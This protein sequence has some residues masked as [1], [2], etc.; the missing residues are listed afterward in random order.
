MKDDEWAQ[1]IIKDWDVKGMLSK[2]SII[3]R[4][5]KEIQNSYAIREEEEA[6]LKGTFESICSEEGLLT[7]TTLISILQRKANLPRSPDGIEAGKVIYASLAP[8]STKSPP[9]LSLAELTRSLVWALPGRYASIIE[10][11]SHSRVRT[12]AD[13]RRLL[14]Q[15]L[16]STNHNKQYDPES[17]RRL[18][19]FNAFDVDRG[20]NHEFCS[21]NHDDDGDEIYH[22]LLDVLYSTQEVRHPGL[23]RVARD[24]FRG[25]AKHMAS[26][27]EMPSLYTIGIPTD[28]F[29]SLVKLLLALQFKPTEANM[30]LTGFETAAKSVCAA[31][32]EE[33]NQV[34]TWPMFDSALRDTVPYLFDPF[35]YMLSTTFLGTTGLFDVLDRPEVTN[36]S[37]G[38]LKPALFSQ[39]ATFLSGGVYFGSL[40]RIHRCTGPTRTSPTEFVGAMESV[41][42]EAIMVL[43]GT[44]SAGESCI[45]GV[46]SPKPR[47]D[48]A[49]VQPN[50]I[51]G[52]VGQEPCSVFQLAPVQDIF[53]G[54]IGK[55]GWT[56]DND[57]VIFGQGGG[58]ILGLKDGLRQVHVTHE[59]HKGDERTGVY[60]SNPWRGSWEVDFEI[61]EME[62]WS[63][64]E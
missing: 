6:A 48:G 16:A 25:V 13:H 17:A 61:S 18:A 14:F 37:G 44:T 58:V 62:I 12:K 32:C 21:S 9:G 33:K 57:T 15:S 36:T 47:A 5:D 45:F 52:H 53:R 42:D 35:Y 3:A 8:P 55:P 10:E 34:I 43:S 24:A 41:P 26:E 50:D 64:Q 4:L 40:R 23:S 38:I 54:A 31:F 59:V 2:E 29:I 19:L 39:L 1:N 30:D 11:G 7:E 20:D 46:F 27:N 63:E 49:S 51:P 22:D 28:R 60:R 56:V